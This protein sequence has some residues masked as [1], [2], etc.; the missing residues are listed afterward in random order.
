MAENS[1]NLSGG[2]VAS[3][4]KSFQFVV[5]IGPKRK[6]NLV[7][8]KASVIQDVRAHVDVFLRQRVGAFTWQPADYF[9]QSRLP[10]PHQLL[11]G[12]HRT[13]P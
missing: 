13:D 3:R 5:G 7:T 2:E 10:S 8:D 11:D 6:L 1:G 4:E 12:S 9:F